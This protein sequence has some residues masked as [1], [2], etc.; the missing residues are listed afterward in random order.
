M[1]NATQFSQ[2]VWSGDLDAVN[3][4]IAAGVDVNAADNP[5]DPPIHLAIEQQWMPIVRRLIE[6]GADIHKELS[7]GWSPLVHAI[8]IES[9]AASQAHDELGHESTE[10]TELLLAA[11]AVPTARAVEIASE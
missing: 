10:L 2:A 8:D 11:G 7:D 6:A 9:D 5:R 1:I 4:M 3:R